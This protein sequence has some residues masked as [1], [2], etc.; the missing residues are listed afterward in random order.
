MCKE[1]SGGSPSRNSLLCQVVLDLCQGNF[2]AV[3]NPCRQRLLERRRISE[4]KKQ[5]QERKEMERRPLA[6]P[7]LVLLNN[8]RD[9]SY[10]LPGAPSVIAKERRKKKKKKRKASLH[11]FWHLKE[12]ATR[13]LAV[14]KC[15]TR[16]MVPFPPLLSRSRFAPVSPKSTPAR[17]SRG[18]PPKSYP[19]ILPVSNGIPYPIRHSPFPV[20]RPPHF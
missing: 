7:S 11:V 18:K 16:C 5:K 13:W 14:C 4:K 6:P 1:G 20:I 2:F 9:M 15:V 12:S 10:A 8:V 3:E 19:T 17:R